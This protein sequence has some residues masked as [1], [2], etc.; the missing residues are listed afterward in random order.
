V[1]SIEQRIAVERLAR[2]QIPSENVC[3]HFFVLRRFGFL[4]GMLA[5]PEYRTRQRFERD[6]LK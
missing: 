6:D 4:L 5:V 3:F 1:N 2:N